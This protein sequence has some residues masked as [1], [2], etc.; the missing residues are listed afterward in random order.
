MRGEPATT[1]YG[2]PNQYDGHVLHAVFGTPMDLFDGRTFLQEL[3][4]RG[5]LL[6]TIRFE[7]KRRWKPNERP[8]DLPEV[9]DPSPAW[10][11]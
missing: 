3:E 7:I 10:N 6:E 4:K 9:P 8:G 11:W 5:Y 1:L 2:L